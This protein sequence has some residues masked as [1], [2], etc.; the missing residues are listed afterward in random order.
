MKAF[1]GIVVLLLL[2]ACALEQQAQPASQADLAV[3]TTAAKTTPTKTTTSQNTTGSSASTTT[4]VAQTDE[5]D[6]TAT[7]IACLD[8]DYGD[9]P[10]LKGTVQVKT[11]NVSILKTDECIGT[12]L[13]EWYCDKGELTKRIYE[14]S[15][16]CDDG[17]CTI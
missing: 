2:A 5:P 1:V 11:Q 6:T 16:G 13:R 12:S 17:A 7:D 9:E 4:T 14:C 8:T 10:E 15:D 3:K